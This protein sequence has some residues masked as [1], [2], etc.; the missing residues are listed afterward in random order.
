MV[1]GSAAEVEIDRADH[2][3]PFGN[4]EPRRPQPPA[5]APL[6]GCLALFTGSVPPPANE[7]R[8]RSRR[9]RPA[10]GSFCRVG[11]FCRGFC[12]ECVAARL[13][14][15]AFF[16]SALGTGRASQPGN[17][18]RCVVTSVSSIGREIRLTAAQMMSASIP[19][20]SGAF[21]DLLDA[22]APS[23]PASANPA[24]VAPSAVASSTAAQPKPAPQRA[25]RNDEPPAPDADAPAETT[26]AAPDAP[27]EDVAENEDTSEDV[28]TDAAADTAADA[29][30]APAPPP[31]TV[32]ADP[33]ALALAAPVA[34]LPAPPP[35]ETGT[36]PA[37]AA[38]ADLAAAAP[39]APAQ[40]AAA[41]E[42]AAGMPA[43][44][45]SAPDAATPGTAAP[46]AATAGT[47]QP[48][49]ASTPVPA[50]PKAASTKPAEPAARAATPVAT[51]SGQATTASDSGTAAATAGTQESGADP[52]KPA[53]NAPPAPHEASADTASPSADPARPAAANSAQPASA[54]PVQTALG[55]APGQPIALATAPVTTDAARSTAVAASDVGVEIVA[56]SKAGD[57]RFELRLDPPELG[58][59]E[60]RL[61][62]DKDG[63]VRSRL[64]VDRAD[65]LD[66]LQRDA[67]QLEKALQ[68]AGLDT[69][70]GGLEFTLRDQS[71][72]F[73]QGS[74]R[75]GWKTTSSETLTAVEETAPA[76]PRAGSYGRLVG[77]SGGLDI[78]V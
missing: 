44:A 70:K 61:D 30:A 39:A 49:D 28:A 36:A 40:P 35:A 32:P 25:S 71:Q 42:P 9:Q 4:G 1:L 13:T 17:G 12:A 50:Q 62:V 33:A 56:R 48:Q 5:A 45:A 20:K 68:A 78:R 75:D 47:A 52:S 69:S 27:A 34:P 6:G 58:R 53:A 64:I 60:V 41:A 11:G 18:V 19:G 76:D 8:G 72:S 54:A 3:G 43:P 59:I 29:S 22:V 51:D 63:G 38:D 15:L 7:L 10:L 73:Q 23:E 21:S 55:L 67:R 74:D 16:P 2:A 37:P 31:E 77:R 24:A 65:T 57:S 26:D 46:E 66:L 14:F